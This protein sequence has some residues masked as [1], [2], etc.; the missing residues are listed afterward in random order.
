MWPQTDRQYVCI[1][2][3]YIVVV[4]HLLVSICYLRTSYGRRRRRRRR[5]ASVGYLASLGWL[6]PNAENRFVR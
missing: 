3:E 1:Y 2:V 5:R 4:F 6:I